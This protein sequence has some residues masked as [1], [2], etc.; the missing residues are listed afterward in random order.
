ML[1]IRKNMKHINIYFSNFGQACS[2]LSW[3][4]QSECRMA[5]R[6]ESAI[7]R[8]STCV[9]EPWWRIGQTGLALC[10]HGNCYGQSEAGRGDRPEDRIIP[11]FQAVHIL[12]RNDQ[13]AVDIS[14]TRCVMAAWVSKFSRNTTFSLGT[15]AQAPRHH[16]RIISKGEIWCPGVSHASALLCH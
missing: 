4:V 2:Q 11:G 14:W 5:R 13:E 6:L 8:A 1:Q 15:K 16:W 7:L 10:H 3:F 12:L 9:F